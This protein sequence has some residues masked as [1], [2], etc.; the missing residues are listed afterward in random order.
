MA[1]IEWTESNSVGISSLDQQHKQLIALTNQL[2]Q[3]IMEDRGRDVVIGVLDKLAD[4]VKYH[5]SYEEELL[6]KYNFPADQREEHV[7][8]HRA[9]ERQVHDFI[10]DIKNQNSL[11]LEVYDF[12]RNWTTN[13][14]NTTDKKYTRLLKSHK[15]E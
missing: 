2:F 6:T 14:L 7:K 9:L 8:E 1:G 5:F 11:D 4:Y 3:A 13:H 12:L 10:K 15:V